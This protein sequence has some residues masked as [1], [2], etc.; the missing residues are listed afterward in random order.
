MGRGTRVISIVDN[1]SNF[2]DQLLHRPRWI[3]VCRR[4]RYL[5]GYWHVRC[6]LVNSNS[7][8][9]CIHFRRGLRTFEYGIRERCVVPLVRVGRL[10][11]D[12]LDAG[13]LL[14][15]DGHH[16][17]LRVHDDGSVVV[18]IRHRDSDLDAFTPAPHSSVLV[19]GLD[20]HLVPGLWLP[21]QRF[22][23][24][25]FTCTANKKKKKR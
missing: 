7:F 16:V 22:F 24:A 4:H 6:G 20:N 12:H 25:Q 3:K 11:G 2:F 15:A 8:I 19:P 18:Y 23:G 10:D 21:V 13:R 9:F 14:F 5:L 17:L 1:T